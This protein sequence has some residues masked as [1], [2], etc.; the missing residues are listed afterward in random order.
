M[1]TIENIEI[2]SLLLAEQGSAPT[3]PASGFGRLYAKP[4]GLFF[5]GD[6]G[7]EVG[8][9]GGGSGGGL[10]DYDEKLR[11][12]GD[13]PLNATAITDVDT[14]LD[15]TL[16]AQAGDIVEYGVQGLL[17]ATAHFVSFDVYTIVGGS[18]VNP[19]GA[20]LSA[21]AG[22][23]SGVSSWYFG[24]DNVH[25]RFGTPATRTL[26]SGDISAGTVTLRLRYAKTNTTARNLKA[27]ANVPLKVWARVYRV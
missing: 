2:P 25:A 3:T 24:Q 26:V 19:F 4:T 14:A 22:T 27:D 18:P 5:V 1:A 12:S 13:I 9:F 17:A 20:G 10:I 6:D 7:V 11:T 8:P 21:S 15:M 23:L 16:T